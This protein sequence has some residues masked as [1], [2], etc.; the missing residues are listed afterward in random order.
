M[1]MMILIRQDGSGTGRVQYIPYHLYP[2]IHTLPYPL[3]IVH[4]PLKHHIHLPKKE[5]NTT[6]LPLPP[7]LLTPSSPPP[8]HPTKTHIPNPYPTKGQTTSKTHRHPACN[9]HKSRNSSWPE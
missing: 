4:E 7:P 8:F 2:T 1:C 5:E 6:P 3:C 9:R